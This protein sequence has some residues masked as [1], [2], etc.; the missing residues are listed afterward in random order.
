[1]IQWLDIMFEPH[2]RDKYPLRVMSQELL[3]DYAI[4]ATK[5]NEL[6]S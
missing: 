3:S 6:N 4:S 2:F 5:T 1:M